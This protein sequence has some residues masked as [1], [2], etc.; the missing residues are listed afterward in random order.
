MAQ[1]KEQKLWQACTDGD[2]EAARELASDSEVDV[3]WAG[4]DRLDTSLHRACSS[5]QKGDPP[6]CGMSEWPHG[7][8]FPLAG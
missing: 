6:L 5:G 1:S 2:L 4:E 7:S 3:N 8:R